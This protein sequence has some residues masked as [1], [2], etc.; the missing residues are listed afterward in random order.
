MLS[1]RIAPELGGSTEWLDAVG[2]NF[3]SDNQWYLEGST[4]PL[5]HQDYRP[6]S[7]MLVETYGRYGRPLLI[8]ETG[9]EGSARPAWFHY[10]CDEVREAIRQGVPLE[11]VCLYPIASF[12]A[13]DD[14]VHRQFGLLG[15]PRPDG[16]RDTFDPLVDE[17]YRQQELLA[18]V[19]MRE[20]RRAVR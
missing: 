19:R 11:G 8:T 7:D 2:L 16:R 20:L 3:Y 5:G 13:W 12:P 10:V 14:G 18:G 1:G 6:L 4:I 9:A 15:A 17:L